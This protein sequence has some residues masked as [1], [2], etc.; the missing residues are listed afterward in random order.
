MNRAAAAMKN[1]GSKIIADEAR[2]RNSS[3][4]VY[5]ACKKLS[6]RSP[7]DFTIFIYKNENLLREEAVT[8]G[9]SMGRAIFLRN[10]DDCIGSYT[11]VAAI[12]RGDSSLDAIPPSDG[13]A[14]LF[15]FRRENDSMK[16]IPVQP[17]LLSMDPTNVWLIGTFHIDA[18]DTT[19]VNPTPNV[20]IGR[21]H[22]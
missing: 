18:T 4:I 8:L 3:V 17:M 22:V 14:A 11:L 21:A 2:K 1:F 19:W 10:D 9:T 7:D 16:L 15:D 13:V 12:R 5:V 6:K 20:Q